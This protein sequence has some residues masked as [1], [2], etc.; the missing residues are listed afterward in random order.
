MYAS[1]WRAVCLSKHCCRPVRFYLCSRQ[2]CTTRPLRQDPKTPREP[3]NSPLDNPEDLP[4][5]YSN[6]EQHVFAKEEDSTPGS[7]GNNSK[8]NRGRFQRKPGPWRKRLQ[9]RYEQDNVP[10]VT[11]PEWFLNDNVKLRN[12]LHAENGGD[13]QRYEVFLE[14]D[15]VREPLPIF[16][17]PAK[18]DTIIQLLNDLTDIVTTNGLLDSYECKVSEAD[19]SGL[20]HNFNTKGPIL[21][22]NQSGSKISPPKVENHRREVLRKTIEALLSKNEQE[23]NKYIPSEAMINPWTMLEITSTIRSCLQQLAGANGLSYP[24]A[25]THLILHSPH[26]YGGSALRTVVENVARTV[27]ANL[28]RLDSQ[29]ISELLGDYIGEGHSHKPTI[30]SIRNLSYDALQNRIDLLQE[31]ENAEEGEEEIDD[32]EETD[33][34]ITPKPTDT[35]IIPSSSSIQDPNSTFARALG[36]MLSNRNNFVKYGINKIQKITPEFVSSSTDTYTAN[37]NDD[38]MVKNWVEHMVDAASVKTASLSQL[39]RNAATLSIQHADA[40]CGKSFGPSIADLSFLLDRDWRQRKL[41]NNNTLRL[42]Q[43]FHNKPKLDHERI[44]TQKTIILLE[45]VKELGMTFNGGRFIRKLQD[46]VQKRRAQGQQIMLIGTSW[47]SD[48]LPEATKAGLDSVQE[49]G[50]EDYSRTILVPLQQPPHRLIIPKYLPT[51]H[52]INEDSDHYWTGADRQRN[53]QI[54]LRHLWDM[55]RRL[56]PLFER[57]PD[58]RTSSIPKNEFGIFHAHLEN[59]ILTFDEIHRIALVATGL[60]DIVSWDTAEMAKLQSVQLALAACTVSMSDISKSSWITERA[61]AQLPELLSS[62]MT[63]RSPETKSNDRNHQ[64]SASRLAAISKSASR[65]EKRLLPG[66]VDS[67]TMKTTFSDVCVDHETIDA[68]QTLTSLSLQRPDAFTY[69]VLA[70]DK[71][72]GVLLYGPPGTGKTLLA[73]AVAKESGATVL[74]VSGSE[75]HDMYVG[76]GEKNV[77]AVFSLARKLSPCVVFLDEADA[78][79]GSRSG[80]GNRGSH[81]E[82]INQ[83]L[84]EW[85]GMEAQ[86]VFVMVATNRPFDLDDAVVR[87]LPRRLLVDLPTKED[88]RKILEIHLK[89]EQLDEEVDLEYLAEKTLLYSGSDLKN[90]AVAAALSCVKEEM[91][92]HGTRETRIENEST[93][94]GTSHPPSRDHSYPKKRILRTHH[95][96]KALQEIG[97]SVSEDMS[98]LAAIRKFDEKYGDRSTKLRRRNKWG[99]EGIVDEDAVRREE[100]RTVRVRV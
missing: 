30:K 33:E 100:E 37:R 21:T 69:G 73:R 84:K 19:A 58:T 87:R 8:R 95:F 11:W 83:F 29:D 14:N 63:L 55:L 34:M 97:A 25:R 38:L 28:V 79:L 77:R 78:I 3:S 22:P 80:N 90:L 82:I 99:F 10:P 76:E 31:D 57:A 7:A 48:Y 40:N 9:E 60:F 47:G 1:R 53:V 43:I 36:D 17:F 93:P 45:D 13:W 49:A 27:G 94:R 67:T 16:E 35:F 71:I 12:E 85:D 51:P 18:Q 50:A 4:S 54:N 86:S 62:R 98:S 64:P 20:H 72:P 66:V 74:E 41:R 56:N 39:P 88:R 44:S 5:T 68:L 2:I 6:N 75:I 23:S 52:R 89:D 59:R 61:S 32:I 26:D 91:R 15:D 24:A 46:V 92:I 81:R 96:A 70:T 65:Y 42:R